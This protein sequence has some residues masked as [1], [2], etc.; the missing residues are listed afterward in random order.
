MW[1]AAVMDNHCINQQHSITV[2]T[3]LYIT[4]IFYLNL[5]FNSKSLFLLNFDDK[6][7][8]RFFLRCSVMELGENRRIIYQFSMCTIDIGTCFLR[9]LVD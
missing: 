3:I 1:T 2:S 6:F 8:S 7:W 9:M 5:K 4:F